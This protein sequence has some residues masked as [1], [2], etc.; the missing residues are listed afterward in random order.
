M[1]ELINFVRDH[2]GLFQTMGLLSLVLFVGSLLVFPVVVVQLPT[3]YFVREQRDPA[4]QR[5][6]HPAVWAVLSVAKNMVGVVLILAGVAM[7][8]LPGQG[9]LTI[10]M[11]VALTNFPGKFTL[12][13]KLF[14][15]PGVRRALNRIRAVAGKTELEVPADEG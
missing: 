3:D 6:R 5:R 11:G 9:I 10:L 15:Q 8:V 13:R 7:L 4:H 14:S 2:Q 1:T 12:E